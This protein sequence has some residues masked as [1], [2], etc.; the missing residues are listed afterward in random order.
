MK[1][2]IE[3]RRVAGDQLAE[4][5]ADYRGRSDVIVL[6]LPRGGVP[7]AYQIARTLGVALDIVLVRK[8]GTPGQ[9]ELAM[10]AL[11]SGGARVLNEDIVA[12][13]DISDEVIEQTVAEEQRELERREQ[14]YRGDRPRPDIA[15]RAVILV[16]DGLATGATMRAAV[17]ALRSQQPARLVAAVPVAPAQ[18]IAGLRREV[19]EVICLE[20]PEPFMA[21]GQWY[22]DFGQ[23]SDT[24][25]RTLLQS[26]WQA[27]AQT[28]DRSGAG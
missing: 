27:Q 14:A 26:A 15:G 8:L 1:L 12:G 4:A 2:P 6:A 13:L 23:V 11:A 9:R 25:V 22:R 19:D 28:Q 3:N 5:L 18:T 16:D 10:G 17:A 24:E 21:I 20:T 7:V